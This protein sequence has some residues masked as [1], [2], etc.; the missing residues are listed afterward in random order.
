[1]KGQKSVSG[2]IG[3][4]ILLAGV[5][6]AQQPAPLIRATSRLVLLDVM[7]TDKAGVQFAT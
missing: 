2:V 3:A 5:A 7:V 6:C 4:I 1:M